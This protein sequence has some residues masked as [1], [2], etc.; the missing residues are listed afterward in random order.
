MFTSHVGTSPSWFKYDE[1]PVRTLCFTSLRAAK[2][3]IN[4]NR[5]MEYDPVRVVV[6]CED[7]S[8]YW[9]EECARPIPLCAIDCPDFSTYE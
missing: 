5:K 7:G 1:A 9:L 2:S 6:R 4:L 8:L 3:W